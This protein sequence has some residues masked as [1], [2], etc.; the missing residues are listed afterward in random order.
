MF[1]EL[2]LKDM[3]EH[4]LKH[5]RRFPRSGVFIGFEHFVLLECL[6]SMSEEKFEELKKDFQFLIKESYG[7]TK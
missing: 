4:C 1:E 6:K 5:I 3:I 2:G 7:K